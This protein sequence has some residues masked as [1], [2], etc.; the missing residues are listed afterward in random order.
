MTDNRNLG[1][2]RK[3]RTRPTQQGP[4]DKGIGVA[5]VRSP[6]F[7]TPLRMGVGGVRLI[8]SNFAATSGYWLAELA[9]PFTNP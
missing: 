1:S 8:A 7:S 2:W 6:H 3:E 4:W 9:V 5:V